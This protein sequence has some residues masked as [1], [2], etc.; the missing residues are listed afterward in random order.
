MLSSVASALRPVVEPRLLRRGVDLGE[1]IARPR[2]A[3][4]IAAPRQLLPPPVPLLRVER[5]EPRV[6][7]GGVGLGLGRGR[8]QR[9]H[10]AEH[11]DR[12]A[13]NERRTI[14]T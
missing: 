12:S 7:G 6:G 9:E 4:L 1:V 5:A 10:G 8:R 3:R 2:L 13:G 11:D 14:S